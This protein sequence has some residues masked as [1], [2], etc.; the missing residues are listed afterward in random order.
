MAIVHQENDFALELVCKRL[1]LYP[2]IVTFAIGAFGIGDFVKLNGTGFVS[3]QKRGIHWQ[4]AMALSKRFS[5]A[6]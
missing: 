2:C 1:L 4:V 3:D 6:T 5:L